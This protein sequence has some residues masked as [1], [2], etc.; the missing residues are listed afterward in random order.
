MLSVEENKLPKMTQ[1]FDIN[2]FLFG[3]ELTII[4]VFSVFFVDLEPI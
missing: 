4:I 1:F 2:D 3:L